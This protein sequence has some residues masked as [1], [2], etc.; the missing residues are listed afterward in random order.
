M[1]NIRRDG[2]PK[3]WVPQNYTYIEYCAMENYG[4]NNHIFNM[5]WG[6]HTLV[7]IFPNL[8]SF[9]FL[10]FRFLRVTSINRYLCFL[11]ETATM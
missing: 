6:G 10:D 7:T 8:C 5:M 11:Q 2:G 4:R 9:R 3:V 1:K